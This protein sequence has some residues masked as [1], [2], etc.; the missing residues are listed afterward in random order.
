M[1]GKEFVGKVLDGKRDFYG[2]RLEEYSDLNK[3]ELN[4]YL[5]D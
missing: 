1:K 2:I 4:P 5:R 3:D